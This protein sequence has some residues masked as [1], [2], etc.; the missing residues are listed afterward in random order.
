MTFVIE[1][2]GVFVRKAESGNILWGP[3]HYQ[4]AHTLTEE[5][6]VRFG[7][8][9][10]TEITKP[11]FDPATQIVKELTPVKTAGVWVQTWQVNA[12]TTEELAAKA[13]TVDAQKQ[14]QVTG[15]DNLQ[16]LVLFDH[17]NRIRALESKAPITTAQFR[18][19]L[20]A[21]L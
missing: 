15:M 6:K 2:N 1:N 11:N 8:S 12:L 13:A 20:K 4:P 14:A 5:E 10:L 19:A 17:E 7:V 16:F 18:A 3:Q 9:L 21:R